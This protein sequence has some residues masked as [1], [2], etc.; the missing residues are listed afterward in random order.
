[1]PL[2]E[3]ALVR[4]RGGQRATPEVLLDI[5]TMEADWVG[6]RISTERF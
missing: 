6:I 2:V 5:L 1:V 4:L 3:G